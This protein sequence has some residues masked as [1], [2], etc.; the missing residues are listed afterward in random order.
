MT[1][2]QLAM[3]CA[4]LAL[5]RTAF[6]DAPPRVEVEG[7]AVVGVRSGELASDK[8]IPFAGPPVR[9][10]RWKAPQPVVPRQGDL[11]ADR[12]S[13]MCLQALR[14]RNSVFYLARSRRARTASIS[15]SGRRHRRA[16]SGRS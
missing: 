10:L 16:R 8:G 11:V 3:L 9:E 13:P 15:M 14:A 12:Y 7:G 2:T 6:A 1:L 4:P 5:A